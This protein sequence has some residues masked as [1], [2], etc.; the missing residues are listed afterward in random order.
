MRGRTIPHHLAGGTLLT[1][2]PPSRREARRRAQIPAQGAEELRRSPLCAASCS[3]NTLAA[4]LEHLTV[5]IKQ[6]AAN[7]LGSAEQ[8]GV[9]TSD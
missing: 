6:L 5:F 1:R 3:V 7:R 8:V 2:C 4:R 9:Y